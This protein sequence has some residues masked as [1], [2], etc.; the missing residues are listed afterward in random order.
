MARTPHQSLRVLENPAPPVP[1]AS[2]VLGTLIFIFTE[3]M[4]FAGMISAHSIAR[5]SSPLTW[6][7][8]GQP[9]LPAEETAFNTAVLLLSGAV[10]W[11]AG[12][13]YRNKTPGEAIKPFALAIALGAFFVVFQGFEWAALL[14]EGLTLTSSQQSGFFYLIVGVHAAHAVVA[15]G[16]LVWAWSK[17]RAG[18]LPAST[19]AAT[20]TFW[21]FVV[22]V[23]PIVYWQV[24]Y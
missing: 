23:W 11:W 15:I 1:I 22:L 10:L 18:F 20:R 7:P 2:A 9:R 19:F 14:R 6:P 13:A 24:Y 8:P 3:I 4:L 12:R 16:F 17:L 5:A 21:Y